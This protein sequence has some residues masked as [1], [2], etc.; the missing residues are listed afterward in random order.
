MINKNDYNQRIFPLSIF[1]DSLVINDSFREKSTYLKIPDSLKYLEKINLKNK[2]LESTLRKGDSLFIDT[3]YFFNKHCA[4]KSKNYLKGDHYYSK[5][6]I[7]QYDLKSINNYKI[8]MF[9][10]PTYVILKK[11]LNQLNFYQLTKDSV[12]TINT[13][14]IKGLENEKKEIMNR[15]KRSYKH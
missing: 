10:L 9:N 3:T 13:R 1:R 14:E 6:G 12:V 7:D 5:W 4:Y 11:Q 15:I 2:I 8:L